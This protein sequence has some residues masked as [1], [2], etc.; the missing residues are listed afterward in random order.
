M[1]R[2][3]SW[4]LHTSGVERRFF[5]LSAVVGA[6][7]WNAVNSL[8]AGA[9]TF[10]VLYVAGFF[11]W[12]TDEHMVMVIRAAVRY[13]SRYDAGLLLETSPYILVRGGNG[14][15]VA[16]TSGRSPMRCRTGAGECVYLSEF[17]TGSQARTGIGGWMDF[18]DRRRPHSALND[19]TPA[20]AYTDDGADG[21]PGLCPGSRQ[22][23]VA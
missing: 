19:R 5:L 9:G 6:G 17:A 23:K 11:A 2:R 13:R 21:S 14:R 16:A 4:W 22:P 12:R 15:C 8:L 20:E 10:A 7:L 3:P 18:Y 1:T